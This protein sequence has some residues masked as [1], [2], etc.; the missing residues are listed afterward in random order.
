MIRHA[1]SIN[2]SYVWYYG[3]SSSR[4]RVLDPDAAHDRVPIVR[5]MVYLD[6]YG[7]QNLAKL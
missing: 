7:E 6:G 1:Y 4:G 2:Y 5:A 3:E